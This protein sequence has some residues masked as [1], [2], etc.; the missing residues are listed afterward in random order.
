MSD[1]ASTAPKSGNL[2]V[3]LATWLY[4]LD[5]AGHGPAS[6]AVADRVAALRGAAPEDADAL[7][8]DLAQHIEVE[9]GD[10]PAFPEVVA[11]LHGLFGDDALRTGFGDARDARLRA[12]R[13]YQFR[14]SLPWLAQVIDRFPNGDVGAHWVMVE[15]VTDRVTC[16][17][18]YPWDDLD[19]EYEQPVVEFM[20][21]WELAGCGA[22][23]WS[24]AR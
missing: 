15:R 10:A 1:T 8:Q 3:T 20:V 21:K 12:V 7:G 4:I 9:L 2:G 23:A 19:E 6:G 16:M 24:D 17:D 14:S 13:A 5:A 18:P 11:W 22:I